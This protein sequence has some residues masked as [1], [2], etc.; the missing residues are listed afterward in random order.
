VTELAV[1]ER[2]RRADPTTRL[3]AGHRLLARFGTVG[4]ASFVIDAG[5]YNLLR[6]LEVG[7]LT[8]KVLAVALATTFSFAANRSWAFGGRTRRRTST[9]YVG[10]VAVNLLALLISVGCLGISYYALGLT[11]PLAENLS[12]NVVGVGLGTAFRFWAYHRWVF[13]DRP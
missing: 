7:P 8:S 4:A 10:F 3:R 12:T 13:P 5:G 2:V 11:S 6:L 1:R 9:T